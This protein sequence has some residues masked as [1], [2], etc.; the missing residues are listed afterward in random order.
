MKFVKKLLFI[1]VTAAALALIAGCA[2][3][4]KAPAEIAANV[5]P[6]Q[7]T[8][9]V[10]DKGASFGIPTPEWVVAFVQSGNLGVEKLP[11]YKDKYCFVVEAIEPS[12]DYAIAWVQNASGPQHIAAKVS[13]TV[14]SSASN[15]LSGEKGGDVESHLNTATEQL[16][17]ASFNGATKDDDWWQIV[18]NNDTGV[19]EC[20]AFALW[21]INKKQLD[22]QVAANLQ[23]IVD[24]NTAMSAAER[25]IYADLINQIRSV[26]GVNS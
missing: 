13:T 24:N 14:A 2:S 12:R 19:E 6:T 22:E 16:S 4:P 11:L 20:R 17:N 7:R 5:T 3:G 26:G 1:S 23:R 10:D 8:I 25:A 18:K 21:V 9:V 15:A